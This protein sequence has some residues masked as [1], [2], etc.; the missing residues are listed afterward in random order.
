MKHAKVIPFNRKDSESLSF[1]ISE[2]NMA[3]R[4]EKQEQRQPQITLTSN[5]LKIRLDDMDVISP[6]TENQKIFFDLYKHNEQFMLLHGVAGTG[7]TYI[8]LYKALEEVLDKSSGY[9]KVIIVRSAVPAREIGHLPG[10]EKEKTEVY[11]EPYVEICHNLFGR[12]DAFQRLQ[13]QGAVH[14]LIT[15]FLRGVTLDNSIIL[16]D[17]CQNLSDAEINTIMTRVGHNSKIIFC[18]DF[19]QTDLVKKNDMSGL[20]KFISIAKMMPAFKLIEFS[21]DDIVRSDIVKQ[22][23]LARLSY[24]E[25]VV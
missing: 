21:V 8:A 7:K 12:H 9:D 17:E 13:E 24:E 25:S 2:G 3:K 1:F 23:I 6:L 15:S 14:F 20:K 4:Q 16:V 10:D 11:K 5:R 22:Y 18:G 19:R